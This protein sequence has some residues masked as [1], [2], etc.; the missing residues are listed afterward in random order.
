[1]D[2][3]FTKI[4][5][6]FTNDLLITFPELKPSIDA[7]NHANTYEHCIE[8]YPKIFFEILYENESLFEKSDGCFLLPG[9]DFALIMKE[10]I[11]E[12]NKKTIWKYLQLILFSILEKINSNKSF[13]ETSK[14][15]EGVEE[16]ELHKKIAETME[17]MKNLF[18]D[19]SDSEPGAFDPSGLDPEKMKSHLDDL[20]NGKIGTLAK[21][22][23]EEAKNS[24]GDEK[25]FMQT[26]MKNPQKILSL[27]KNIGGKLEEKI[28]SGQVKESELLEEATQIMDKIQDIPGLKEIMAKMGLNGKMDFKAMANKMQQ[29]MKGSK[30]KERLQKKREMKQNQQSQQNQQNQQNQGKQSTQEPVDIKQ[31]SEDTFVFKVGESPQKSTKRKNKNKKKKKETKESN[32]PRENVTDA[33]VKSAVES[34]SNE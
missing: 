2:E 24:I 3:K 13:G 17:E 22:I 16:N 18:V 20:M 12:K 11:S 9:I 5:T 4:I 26:V 7:I 31:T 28:S 34:S 25:E 21:E 33:T 6:D 27:V 15:F 14:I 23:A 30:T 32:E 29:H 8:M 10:N 1:M 19:V